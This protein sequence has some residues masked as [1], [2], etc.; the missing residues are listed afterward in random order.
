MLLDQVGCTHQIN[1]EYI[2]KIGRINGVR[3]SPA[4]RLSRSANIITLM[5]VGSDKSGSIVEQGNALT[6]DTLMARVVRWVLLYIV[7]ALYCNYLLLFW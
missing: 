2:K 3:L 1:M 5:H 7:S 6:L 4:S